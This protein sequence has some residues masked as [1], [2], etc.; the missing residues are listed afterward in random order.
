MHNPNDI[1]AKITMQF[2]TQQQCEKSL[3]SM[4]YWMKFENFKIEGKCQ[5]IR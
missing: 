1:P 5:K 4:S 2:D 3:Q